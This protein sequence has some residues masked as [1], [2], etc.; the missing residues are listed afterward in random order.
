VNELTYKTEPA[1][2]QSTVPV[3]PAPAEPRN[4][5]EGLGVILNEV[6]IYPKITHSA[7][8]VMHLLT[9]TIS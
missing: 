5:V 8:K 1:P 4:N 3:P 6:S 9:A 2:L 7:Y